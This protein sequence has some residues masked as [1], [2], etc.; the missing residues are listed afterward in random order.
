MQPNACVRKLSAHSAIYAVNYNDYLLPFVSFVLNYRLLD[1]LGD[2]TPI[3]VMTGRA[4]RLPMDLVLWKRN[5]I[6]DAAKNQ[7]NIHDLSTARPKT[8]N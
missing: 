3:E 1:P 4:P 6:K 8:L 2:R 7:A 5:K